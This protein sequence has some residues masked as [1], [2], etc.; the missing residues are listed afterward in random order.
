M[1][2][3][4]FVILLISFFLWIVPNP[5]DLYRAEDMEETRDIET[6]I[7]QG[8]ISVKG[9]EPHTFLSLTTDSNIE[10][11]LTGDYNDKIRRIYQLQIITLKGEIKRDAIGPG[12]PAL[13][14]VQKIVSVPS[15]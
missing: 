15:D 1:K 8:R 10:Y 13:F 3:D 5:L 12:F 2:I 7:I 14:D 9:N 6:M 4:L 11:Q